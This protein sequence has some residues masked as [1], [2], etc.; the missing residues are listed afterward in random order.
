[1][2]MV[3]ERRWSGARA[4]IVREDVTLLVDD[5]QIEPYLNFAGLIVSDKGIVIVE[6][7]HYRSRQTFIVTL[8]IE[9]VTT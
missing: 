3:L 9:S 5:I 2:T 6:V 7:V 4:K 8:A 1:M